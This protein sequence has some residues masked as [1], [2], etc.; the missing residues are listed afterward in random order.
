MK[1]ACVQQFLAS[2]EAAA[3]PLPMWVADTDFRAPQVVIDA[4]HQAVDHGVFRYPGARPTAT[5]TP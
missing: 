5:S 1:W 2:D 3:D 4:L